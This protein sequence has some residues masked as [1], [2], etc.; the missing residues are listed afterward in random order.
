MATKY[1]QVTIA[2]EAEHEED[3]GP[4]CEATAKVLAM[5]IQDIAQFDECTPSGFSYCDGKQIAVW[6]VVERPV[7]L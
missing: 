6:K 5:V 7:G 2:V 1:V 3:D 4:T